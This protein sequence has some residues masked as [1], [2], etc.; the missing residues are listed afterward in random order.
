MTT[1]VEDPAELCPTPALELPTSEFVEKLA[2][3][4]FAPG[5]EPEGPGDV[6]Q[7]CVKFAHVKIVVFAKNTTRLRLPRKAAVLFTRDTY[8]SV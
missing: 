7:S 1:V 6:E 4:P 3:E 8:G 5:P 2:G